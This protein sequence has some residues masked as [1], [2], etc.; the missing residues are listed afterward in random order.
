M[1]HHPEHIVLLVGGI[2]KH[3]VSM[4][5]NSEYARSSWTSAVGQN[6]DR[7]E[8]HL[9]GASARTTLHDCTSEYVLPSLEVRGALGAARRWQPP[10]SPAVVS[11]RDPSSVS[12]VHQLSGG[13]PMHLAGL[14]VTLPGHPEAFCNVGLG[15]PPRQHHHTFAGACT[16]TALSTR[17]S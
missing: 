10:G 7:V 16:H 14:L 9:F 17:S 13:G 15:A 1:G 6:P 11:P 12:V 8:L 5:L 3:T 4:C 2:Y